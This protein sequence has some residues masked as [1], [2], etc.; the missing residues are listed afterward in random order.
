[1][2]A[3]VIFNL[4]S[5]ACAASA[6]QGLSI[7]ARPGLL[8]Y[9]EGHV[10]VNG[11][12]LTSSSSDLLNDGDQLNTENGKAELLLVP[13]VF[14]RL[15]DKSELFMVS[16]SSVSPRIELAQGEALIEVASLPY[17]SRIDVLD[18][19]AVIKIKRAGL[20]R[21]TA[22]LNPQL[23]VFAGLAE[24]AQDDKRIKVEAGKQT[25]L[26]GANVLSLEDLAPPDEDSLYDWSA[27]RSE[28]AA[29]Q[30][31]QPS[32][33][34]DDSDSNNGTWAPAE[35]APYNSFSGSAA[36]R[37]PNQDG[38]EARVKLYRTTGG[39]TTETEPVHPAP[40]VGHAVDGSTAVKPAAHA[41]ATNVAETHDQTH[42]QASNTPSQDHSS[43]HK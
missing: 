43:G 29:Q 9:F 15:G 38:T 11:N 16:V 36:N 7:A 33:V 14:L 24:V 41:A 17:P 19:R 34:A 40:G 30:P 26:S 23:G 5:Y 39:R 35:G 31:S 27:L 4:L 37:T 3:K 18:N 13:G 1:M 22:G 25:P 20:Y 12:P 10:S 42:N 8:N 2:F 28:T 6:G 32:A 21:I